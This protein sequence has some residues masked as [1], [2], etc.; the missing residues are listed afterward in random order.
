MKNEEVLELSRRFWD[1]YKLFLQEK[2]TRKDLEKRFE[3][4]GDVI[5]YRRHCN[6]RF[7]VQPSLEEIVGKRAIHTF[8]YLISLLRALTPSTR[9]KILKRVIN[10]CFDAADM[11]NKKY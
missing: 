11:E 1:G 4:P 5:F 9:K 2:L 6:H 3:E 8:R 7:N 10:L